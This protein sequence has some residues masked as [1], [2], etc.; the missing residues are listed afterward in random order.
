MRT[1]A[2]WAKMPKASQVDNKDGIFDVM[3]VSHHLM[4]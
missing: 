1:T 2:M 3:V 4:H